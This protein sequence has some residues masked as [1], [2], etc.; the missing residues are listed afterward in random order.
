MIYPTATDSK[1][2]HWITHYAN[3]LNYMACGMP[4]GNYTFP[5]VE[6]PGQCVD[7]PRCASQVMAYEMAS[8]EMEVRNV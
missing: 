4:L 2:R 7:C 8:L 1:G 6:M 3:G 5:P